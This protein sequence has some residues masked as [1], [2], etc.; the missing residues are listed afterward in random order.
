MILASVSSETFRTA[1]SSFT[2][3]DLTMVRLLP[4]I[5]TS[6]WLMIAAGD[7]SVSNTP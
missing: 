7:L 4:S 1:S 6:R 5:A 3:H 2:T